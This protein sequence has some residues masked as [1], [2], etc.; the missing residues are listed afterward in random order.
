MM[1][2]NTCYEVTRLI[3]Y[4]TTTLHA[5]NDVLTHVHSVLKC[6][7]SNRKAPLIVLLP[8]PQVC[9]AS[10]S[11]LLTRLLK[12][13]SEAVLLPITATYKY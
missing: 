1:T 5:I 9:N 13:C 10:C 4:C 3:F 6:I 7:L 12:L 2:M 11:A 8:L